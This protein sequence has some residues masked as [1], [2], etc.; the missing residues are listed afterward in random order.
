MGVTALAATARL[1]SDLVDVARLFDVPAPARRGL[2]ARALTAFGE[3][4]TRGLTAFEKPITR[5]LTAFGEPITLALTAFGEPITLEPTAF[6][7][8]ITLELTAFGEPIT[9]E[10]T[11][12]REP[13]TRKLVGWGELDI[14]VCDVGRAERVDPPSAKARPLGQLG[15]LRPPP[16]QVGT[17]GAGLG[18]VV[19]G[20]ES[21]AAGSSA[22]GCPLGGSNT[23]P[24]CQVS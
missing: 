17:P 13:F 16:T 12:L 8:P 23:R 14:L 24:A 21:L 1:A 3:P 20:G 6:G 22:L 11:A 4:I 10:Q 18:G 7:E 9:L 15:V 19:R 5:G 2:T